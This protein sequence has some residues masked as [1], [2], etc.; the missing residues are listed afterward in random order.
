EIHVQGLFRI[1]N[2]CGVYVGLATS[3]RIQVERE[4]LRVSI[5]RTC[6]ILD[7]AIRNE[8]IIEGAARRA[9]RSY[10]RQIGRKQ[11]RHDRLS[12]LAYHERRIGGES[13]IKWAVKHANGL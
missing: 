2:E 13:E 11:V 4:H 5:V 9:S 12:H 8:K 1:G 7:R 10:E 6:L 3:R